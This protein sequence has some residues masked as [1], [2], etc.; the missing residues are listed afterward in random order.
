MAIASIIILSVFIAG[1]ISALPTNVPEQ[2]PSEASKL[3]KDGLRELISYIVNQYKIE[4][5]Q[6]T[7][8]P[9]NYDEFVRFL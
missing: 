2:P 9:E 1:Q 3:E 4:T 7:A 6:E 5:E 8:N